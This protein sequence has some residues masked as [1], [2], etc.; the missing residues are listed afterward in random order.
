VEN[1][2]F[3][4]I[5][6]FINSSADDRSWRAKRQSQVL[7]AKDALAK[8]VATALGI[9][10]NRPIDEPTAQGVWGTKRQLIASWDS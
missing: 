4:P 10:A 1:T 2:C 5:R 6:P 7:A 9:Y 3:G 8:V